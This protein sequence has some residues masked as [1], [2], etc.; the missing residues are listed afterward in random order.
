MP[1]DIVHLLALGKLVDQLVQEPDFLHQRIADVFDAN[2]TPKILCL[3]ILFPGPEESI[4]YH[5]RIF[6]GAGFANGE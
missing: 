6:N 5:R 2:V 3:D 4:G 1:Q